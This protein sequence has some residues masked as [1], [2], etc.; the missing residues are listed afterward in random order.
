MGARRPVPS[1]A[2]CLSTWE[3]GEKEDRSAIKWGLVWSAYKRCAPYMFYKKKF[4]VGRY[5]ARCDLHLTF[6]IRTWGLLDMRGGH[7]RER[8]TSHL[9]SAA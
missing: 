2:G 3:D 1:W 4:W 9:S 8:C 7:R 5:P 6:Y